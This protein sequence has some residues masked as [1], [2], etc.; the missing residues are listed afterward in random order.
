M[1]QHCVCGAR[2]A[3]A[4]GFTLQELAQMHFWSACSP[5]AATVRWQVTHYYFNECVVIAA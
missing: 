5:A 4:W 1:R 3:P 2:G